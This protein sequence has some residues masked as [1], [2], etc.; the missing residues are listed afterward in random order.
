MKIYPYLTIRNI[1]NERND[2]DTKNKKQKPY[3]RNGRM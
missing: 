1:R 2:S 3:M